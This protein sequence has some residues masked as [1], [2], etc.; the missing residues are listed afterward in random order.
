MESIGKISN[1]FSSGEYCGDTAVCCEMDFRL[2]ASGLPPAVKHQYPKGITAL[3]NGEVLLHPE[4]MRVSVFRRQMLGYVDA[5][6]D[7]RI[8]NISLL[9]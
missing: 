8:D 9:H 5:V 6:S 1:G 3:E 2:K 7:G 4:L